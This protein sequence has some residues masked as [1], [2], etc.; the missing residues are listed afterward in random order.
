MSG[1]DQLHP[2]QLHT[3]RLHTDRLRPFARWLAAVIV[4]FLVVAS[5]LLYGFPTRTETLFAWTIQPPITAMFLACAYIGGIWYFVRV[6]A[7]TRTHRVQRGLPA[8]MVFA[9]LAGLAT[10]LHLDKFHAGTFIFITWL[11]LYLTTPFLATAAWL[12]GRRESSIV[13]DTIDYLIPRVLR[14]VL[15]T[16]GAIALVA[17]LGLFVFA[18]SLTTLWAW[19]LTPLTAR[20]VGAILTLPG[21]VNL[22]MLVD[23]RWSSFRILFQAQLVSLVFILATIAIANSDLRFDRPSAPALVIGLIGSFVGYL[24]FYLWCE[25]STK[26]MASIPAIVPVSR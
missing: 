26:R 18:E 25:R 17:G 1:A 24:L 22:G 5:I 9:T 7:E 10:L 3:D 16:L 13:P 8:V 12:L 6:A 23:A 2:D 14:I 15:I 11:V 19:D 20:I 21:M 4:P